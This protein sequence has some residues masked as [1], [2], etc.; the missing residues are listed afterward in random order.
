MNVITT[1]LF[2]LALV[3]GGGGD[4]KATH[5]AELQIRPAVTVRGLGVTIGDLCDIQPAGL[6]AVAIAAIAFGPSPTGG[7]ARTVSRTEIVQALAAA[8]QDLATLKFD[9]A[10][11]VIV[12]TAAVEVPGQDLVES[13]T[14][15]LQALL[16]I[17]GGDVEYELP[18][19]QRQVQAPP[20]RRSQE[21][22]ARVRG[23][24]T[25]PTMAIVDVDV[26]VDG[27]SF[28]RVPVTFKLTRFQNVLKTT[29]TIRA[30]T[31]LGP[32]NL[33]VARE[34]MAQA[35]G[36]FLGAMAQ[37]DGQQAA[38]NLQPGQRLTLGDTAPPSVVHKGDVV[39]VVLTKGRVKVTARAMA[40]HDAPLA[41]RVTLTNLQSRSTLTG[42][43]AGPGIVVVH[44]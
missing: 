35:S 19:R 39:T 14:A 25:G 31:P 27:E 11:E 18:L 37:I 42:V 43:V 13:A 40:N 29:G 9:G 6:D 22:Q 2:A 1:V 17:E 28:K 24:R 44:N 3:C 15:A 21:L 12:Q 20:G 23:S 4:E 26:L 5:R 8:G 33:T 16:A 41:G 38:R 7:Y 34:P 10:K 30:G 36:L 32:E